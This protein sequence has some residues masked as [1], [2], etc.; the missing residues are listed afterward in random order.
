MVIT[1]IIS[2]PDGT[3]STLYRAFGEHRI[4]N[5]SYRKLQCDHDAY[6]TWILQLYDPPKTLQRTAPLHPHSRG[7]F[8]FLFFENR[9]F[10]PLHKAPRPPIAEDVAPHNGHISQIQN[11]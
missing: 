2:V 11:Q 6:I 4:H 7:N 10:T 1:Q 9:S 3:R 8:C 5:W